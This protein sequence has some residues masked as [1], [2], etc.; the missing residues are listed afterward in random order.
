G[1]GPHDCGRHRDRGQHVAER[2][3]QGDVDGGETYRCEDHR[4][5]REDAQRPR[6]LHG[7][8]LRSAGAS[9]HSPFTGDPVWGHDRGM[10]PEINWLAVLLAAVSSMVVG[11]IW[12]AKPV[13][14]TRWMKLS[15]ITDAD[16]QKGAALALILTFIVS[17]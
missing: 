17:F 6:R 4:G 15:G 1:D 12:Y 9:R 16:T 11:A 10:V 7:V 8:R 3:R 5:E 13:F 14:G 2:G